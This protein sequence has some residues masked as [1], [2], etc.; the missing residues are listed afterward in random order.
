[1]DNI[2]KRD[3]YTLENLNPQIASIYEKPNTSTLV[4]DFGKKQKGDL[5]TIG[6]LYTPDSEDFK[7]SNT[8]ASC[9]CTK[10]TLVNNEDG[11]QFV[12]IEYASDKIANNISKSITFYL[13]NKTVV[14]FNLIMNTK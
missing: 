5:T 3:G 2:I 1:M 7:I 12:N 14:K 8:G 6:V 9:G 11:T 13:K 10:P 4:L